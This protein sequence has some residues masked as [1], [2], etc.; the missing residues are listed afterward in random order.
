MAATPANQLLISLLRLQLSQ[1][2]INSEGDSESSKQSRDESETGEPARREHREGARRKHI[3]PARRE[4]EESEKEATVDSDSDE[5][6]NFDAFEEVHPKNL[7]QPRKK[8]DFKC[9]QCEKV[10]RNAW[11]LERHV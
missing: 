2:T 3:E 5:E 6:D 8:G 9:D 1:S 10:C 4:D 7:P 11:L